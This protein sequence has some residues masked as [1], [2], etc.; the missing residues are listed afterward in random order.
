MKMIDLPRIRRARANLDR[1]AAEHPEYLN[2]GEP[3]SEHLDELESLVMSTP[4]RE[5]TAAY[6]ARL[7]E[8]GRRALHV[9]VPVDVVELVQTIA[10]Q[11]GQSRSDVVAAAIRRT[12]GHDHES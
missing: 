11:T 3:W 2:Q 6:R 4:G 1:L 5:R 10:D 12:Y 9:S 8:Q 7:K